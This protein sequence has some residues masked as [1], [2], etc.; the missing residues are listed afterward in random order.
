MGDDEPDRVLVPPVAER[1]GVERH[2]YALTAH[3][4]SG[5]VDAG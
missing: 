3:A 2:L 1:N 4:F 5:W